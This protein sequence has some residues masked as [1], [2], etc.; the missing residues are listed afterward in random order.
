MLPLSPP[1]LE[2]LSRRLGRK[3]LDTPL[4]FHKDGKLI[5]DWRK[6]WNRA[7]KEAGLPG[8]LFH[9]CRRTAARNY[10]RAG[11]PEKVAMELTGHKTRSVFST[12]N[13]TD[14]KDLRQATTRLAEYV[15]SQST[16]PTVVPLKK[17]S[18]AGKH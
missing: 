6:T 8:K 9:D 12:C 5:G 4:V 13:I 15:A 14:E 18:K 3:R 16:T 1:L 11:V 10:V 2:V 7:C 17:V